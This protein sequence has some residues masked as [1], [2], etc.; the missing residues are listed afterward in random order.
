MM[1]SISC[2]IIGVLGSR[3]KDS[4]ETPLTA[5]DIDN[6]IEILKSFNAKNWNYNGGSIWEWSE[7]KD[8]IKDNIQNLKRLR[9]LMNK[10]TLEV[11]FIDSY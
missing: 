10:Y 4:L 3:W 8:Y 2:A 11:V 9:E 7:Y 6:I 1:L 5:Q